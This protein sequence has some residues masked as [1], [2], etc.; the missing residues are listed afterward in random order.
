MNEFIKID[1]N[2][3]YNIYIYRINQN[4]MKKL[5]KLFFKSKKIK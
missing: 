3:L 2:I 1:K 4:K 5:S